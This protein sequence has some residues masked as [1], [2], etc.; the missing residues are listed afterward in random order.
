MCLLS[1]IKLFGSFQK[2]VK[3]E[4]VKYGL[5]KPSKNTGHPIKYYFTNGRASVRDMGK[6]SRRNENK[7]PVHSPGWS[8]DGSSK[9]R[10]QMRKERLNN[11]SITAL[12]Q[13]YVRT[14]IVKVLPI[15]Q[16]LTQ[17]LED[18]QWVDN[19]GQFTFFFVNDS[20]VAITCK[21]VFST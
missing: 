3:E 4:P 1:G 10:N 17:Y 9:T 13:M 16:A 21:H 20:G 8:H 6:K 2:E 11:I 18:I 19:A 5:T 12:N 15:H 14:G 7:I